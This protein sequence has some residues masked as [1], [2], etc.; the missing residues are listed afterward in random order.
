MDSKIV[1]IAGQGETWPIYQDIVSDIEFT[2]PSEFMKT[3][4][5]TYKSKYKSK[6]YTIVKRKKSFLWDIIGCSFD[7]IGYNWMQFRR[8]WI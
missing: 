6:L 7:V 4:Y 1:G 8:N 5:E 2:T 3:S